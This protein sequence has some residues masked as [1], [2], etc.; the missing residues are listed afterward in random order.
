MPQQPS[1]REI[2]LSQKLAR[3]AAQ[4]GRASGEL[5]E[6][7]TE[8]KLL[9]EKIDGLIRRLFGAQSEKLDPAQLRLLLQGLDEP[10]KAPEPVV[11]SPTRQPPLSLPPPR[12]RPHGARRVNR[13]RVS[14]AR[15]G[16]R[17]CRWSRK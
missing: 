5:A 9:R 16:R 13:L 7:R 17:I 2:E 15:A 8:N 6:L 1:P 3:A 10:G 11:G 4:L 14:A 12:R